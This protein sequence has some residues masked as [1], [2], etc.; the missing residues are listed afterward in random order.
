MYSGT[1]VQVARLD[2]M[3]TVVDSSN[4]WSN[5]NTRDSLKARKLESD[6]SDERHISDLM[7]EQVCVHLCMRV[8]VC[9]HV[10][11]T[12]VHVLRC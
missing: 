9:I 11:H 4:F 3:V 1:V 10:C 12:C 6:P 2:T 8:C 7:V 5:W